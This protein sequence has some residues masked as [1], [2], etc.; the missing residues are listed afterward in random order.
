MTWD[1]G[2]MKIGLNF[3]NILYEGYREQVNVV[4]T[5]TKPAALKPPTGVQSVTT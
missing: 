4:Q 1:M 3:T 2:N 5:K